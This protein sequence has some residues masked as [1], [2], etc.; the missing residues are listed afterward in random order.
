MQ[1]VT[2]RTVAG[3][4]AALRTSGPSQ[5]LLAAWRADPARVL[6]EP[7]FAGAAILIV[8]A[9]FTAPAR[10]GH[11]DNARSGLAAA[12]AV[13]GS[14]FLAMIAPGF[15]E[16]FCQAMTTAGVLPLC[17]PIGKVSELQDIV[18]AEPATPLIVDPGNQKV[19]AGDQFYAMFEIA[20]R[21]AGRPPGSQAG[22][23][24]PARSVDIA[25][26]E[27]GSGDQLNTVESAQLAD[28]MRAAQLRISCLDIPADVR[29]H[30]QRR[31]VAVCDAMK[32]AT[33]DPAR[34]ER[35]LASLTAELDRLAAARRPRKSPD[36]NS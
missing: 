20:G 9:A 35:R 31:L 23:G 13:A 7:R 24:P 25:L 27:R 4:G 36:C 1:P 3:R 8:S 28:R 21:A 34:C 18:D 30:L 11:S 17:L 19:L 10:H 16:I 2:G 6:S 5:D 26:S 12:A 32:A 33:A 29:I 14:G 15:G 22:A